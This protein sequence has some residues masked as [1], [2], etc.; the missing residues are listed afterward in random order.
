MFVEV[1]AKT[2]QG[3][4]ALLER[5]LLQAEVLE[6]NRITSYNVCYTKLLRYDPARDQEYR[7]TPG[8]GGVPRRR[9][10]AAGNH[11][12]CE[13]RWRPTTRPTREAGRVCPPQAGRDPSAMHR[14]AGFLPA[15]RHVQKAAQQAVSYNFV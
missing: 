1:S 6:L 14:H 12:G 9:A 8:Q 15:R 5:V 4:D 11:Q 7:E 13:R 10:A 3:I 2:G